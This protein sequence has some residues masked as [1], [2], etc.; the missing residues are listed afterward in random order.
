VPRQSHV[1]M[2]NKYT[3]RELKSISAFAKRRSDSITESYLKLDS[4]ENITKSVK[5]IKNVLDYNSEDEEHQNVKKEVSI[6]NNKTTNNL[7]SN[8][9]RP[10]TTLA[11]SHNGQISSSRSIHNEVKY[12]LNDNKYY[13]IDEQNTHADNLLMLSKPTNDQRFKSLISSMSSFKPR[14]DQ[15]TNKPDILVKKLINSNT[16]L[17]K[18]GTTSKELSDTKRTALIEINMKLFEKIVS[19]IN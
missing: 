6:N 18:Q 14:N 10:N 8:L 5:M 11:L 13:I 16:A 15:E 9:K 2:S 4:S 7:R 1:S 12:Q 17:Q 3:N 19:N